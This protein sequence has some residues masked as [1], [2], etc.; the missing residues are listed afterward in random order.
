MGSRESR[1]GCGVVCL[2]HAEPARDAARPLPEQATWNDVVDFGKQFGL[3]VQ[4]RPRGA[5]GQGTPPSGAASSRP[6]LPPT[7]EDTSV[8]RSGGQ[9]GAPTARCSCARRMGSGRIRA[10]SPSGWSTGRAAP[11]RVLLAQRGPARAGAHDL[12]E[13][14]QASAARRAG[15]LERR[16]SPSGRW[17]CFPATTSSMRCSQLGAIYAGV[18]YAPVSPAYSLLSTDFAKLRAYSRFS[19][20]G[21]CSFRTRCLQGRSTLCAALEVIDTLPEDRADA[22]RWT[23]AHAAVGPTRSRSS[24]SPPARPARRRR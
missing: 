23:Q 6:G 12:C 11:D 4:L 14:P 19:R 15:L 13:A 1:W 17:R 22:R 5:G 24:C 10:S 2:L 16:L 3:E 8:R 18:P 21:W 7:L 20:R 9:G